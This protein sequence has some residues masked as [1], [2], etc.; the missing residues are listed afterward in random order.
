MCTTCMPVAWGGQE[1]V[2]DPWHW[3]YR[4]LWV[5]MCVGAKDQTWVFGESTCVLKSINLKS[6]F[7]RLVAWWWCL[8]S[9]VNLTNFSTP[10]SFKLG[11]DCARG[12]AWGN[13]V[14]EATPVEK[15]QE[16]HGDPRDLQQ[17]QAPCSQL[18][19]KLK[20]NRVH[21]RQL[22]ECMWDLTRPSRFL[23]SQSQ[24]HSC[25]FWYKIYAKLQNK[26][27]IFISQ[28]LLR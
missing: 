16:S 22:Q 12:A 5:T 9:A 2:L 4:R 18:G 10:T 26:S 14:A 23:F 27:V 8:I 11:R 21:F 1:M 15:R 13:G 24:G 7:V 19:H 20:Q 3:G 25:I 6:M 17:H 28:R